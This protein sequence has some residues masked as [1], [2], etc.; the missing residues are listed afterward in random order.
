MTMGS[1]VQ[2]PESGRQDKARQGE[3]QDACRILQAKSLRND[4]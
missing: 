3:C 1:R 2:S 4:R